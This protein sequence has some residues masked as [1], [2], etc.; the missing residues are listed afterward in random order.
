MSVSLTVWSYFT[1]L[2]T[3]TFTN[4]LIRFIAVLAI[5]YIIIYNYVLGIAVWLESGKDYSVGYIQKRITLRPKIS[6]K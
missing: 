5:I 1:F 2:F 3:F 4:C 6:N